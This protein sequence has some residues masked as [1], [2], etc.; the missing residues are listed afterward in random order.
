MSE[1]DGDGMLAFWLDTGATANVRRSACRAALEI[2]RL[3]TQPDL[4]PG[5]PP[6]P[7]RVGI[8]G[9]LVSLARVGASRHHEYRVVGDA[10]NTASRIEA[11]SKHLGTRLLV[12][13]ELRD[14][15]DQLLTR[16]LGEFLLVGKGTSVRVHELVAGPS[17]VTTPQQ[18]LCAGFAEALEAFAARR[19]EDA[20]A[21]FAVLLEEF[22]QDGPSRF[23]LRIA[24]SHAAEPPP[25]WD[26]IIRM[27]A[28]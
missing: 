26:G 11:L 28:K 6:L 16:P 1:I 22:P 5:W 17:E 3:T 18:R 12:S 21:R 7:T 10:A 14:G 23:Y 20:A 2:V 24:L 25:R 13:D 15:F 27:A 4:L 8:H 19:W 9:G